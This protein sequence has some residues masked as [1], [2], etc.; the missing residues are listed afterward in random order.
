M[1]H[2]PRC[3]PAKHDIYC[4]NCGES[5]NMVLVTKVY[6]PL[7]FDRSLYI[8]CCNKRDCSLNAAGWVVIRNQAPLDD[9]RLPKTMKSSAVLPPPAAPVAS[10][11]PTTTPNKATTSAWGDFSFDEDD[12][13]NSADIDD[14][15]ELLQLRDLTLSANK[16]PTAPALY[17][18]K[19]ADSTM[20]STFP[21]E[22]I[23]PCYELA[24]E[25]EV[26]S[27]EDELAA[28]EGVSV[29]DTNTFGAVG[30][31]QAEHIDRLL[32]SYFEGE[33]DTEIVNLLKKHSSVHSTRTKCENTS[34]EEDNEELTTIGNSTSKSKN[35]NKK[36]DSDSEDEE[37]QEAGLARST[38]RQRTEA[39]FQYR[40]SYYPT[41]ALRYAYAGEPLWI[42]HPS[43]FDT[44]PRTAPNTSTT[45]SLSTSLPAIS[46]D[47]DTSSTAAAT[48][49]ASDAG[50]KLSSSS[51]TGKAKGK[52]KGKEKG[53]KNSKGVA[54][55]NITA[56]AKE[57]ESIIPP[58]ELCGKAR[59]F[60]CQLMPA[61]LS[62]IGTD[63]TNTDGNTNSSTSTIADRKRMDAQQQPSVADIQR[64]QACLGEG[65]D[66]GVVA[67]FSCPDSCYPCNKG[68]PFATEFAIVQGPPDI[69]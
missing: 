61:L 44:L 57:K 55:T 62:L 16:E 41:Q 26:W 63:N 25:E 64:F 39:Y 45:T 54:S 3:A 2:D 32:N 15:N 6:A 47:R 68:Q 14:L 7:D 22:T 35:N 40:A 11:A 48:A 59:V 18:E 49:T 53:T 13:I 1:W 36:A 28:L 56:T 24:E 23:L 52:E 58:C 12:G 27:R 33:E 9:G 10:S 21:T 29:E 34:C 66:F 46:E 4:K 69:L 5:K 43:P 19:G 38:R 31:G 51:A 60:E 65:L 8:F 42:T 30:S 50:F 67:V 20:D 37:A 17:G